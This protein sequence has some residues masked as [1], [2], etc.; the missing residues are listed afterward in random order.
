MTKAQLEQRIKDLEGEVKV[1]ETKLYTAKLISDGAAAHHDAQE[2]KIKN[3]KAVLKDLLVNEP[4]EEE[5]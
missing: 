5:D 2:K 3:L 1:L 4:E